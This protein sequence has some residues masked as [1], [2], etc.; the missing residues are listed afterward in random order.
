MKLNAKWAKT[1]LSENIS[2][3][4]RNARATELTASALAAI[5]KKNAYRFGLRAK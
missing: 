4:K 3:S 2:G 5:R 1:R